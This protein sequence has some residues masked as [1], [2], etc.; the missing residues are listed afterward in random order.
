MKFK[1]ENL[2]NKKVIAAII[3]VVILIGGFIGYRNHEA[4]DFF[5]EVKIEFNG[6]NNHGTADWA[7]GSVMAVSKKIARYEGKKAKVNKDMLNTIVDTAES[8]EDLTSEDKWGTDTMSGDDLVK[9]QTYLRHMRTTYMKISQSTGL[10]NGQKIQISIYDQSP[11]PYFKMKTKTYTVSGLKKQPTISM[12]ELEQYTKAKGSGYNHHGEVQMLI[13]KKSTPSLNVKT[14]QLDQVFNLKH[15]FD[16]SNGDTVKASQKD[17]AT[18]L[19]R[20]E[21]SIKFTYHKGKNVIIK[22]SGLKDGSTTPTNL[23]AFNE[24]LLAHFHDFNK[25][26]DD[27]DDD[28]DSTEDPNLTL[29]K[30]FLDKSEDTLELIY[31]AKANDYYTL[32]LQDVKLKNNTLKYEDDD[33]EKADIFDGAVTIPDSNDEITDKNLNNVKTYSTGSNVIDFNIQ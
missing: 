27:D 15:D 3:V 13:S 11:D 33:I 19:D 6:Y 31:K 4:A 9:V 17:L 12:D 24:K 26:D 10:K 20:Y 25:D 23:N 21:P 30:A 7:N 29:V 32:E 18:L 14:M 28:E 22:V 2:K 1:L 16:Y 5:K 8:P